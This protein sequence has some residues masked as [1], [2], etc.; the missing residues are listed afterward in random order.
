MKKTFV[1]MGLSFPAFRLFVQ[2][3]V[4]R[5]GGATG[6]GCGTWIFSCC[7]TVLGYL[8]VTLHGA[9]NQMMSL[10]GHSNS[11]AA[12]ESM[13]DDFGKYGRRLCC[14]VQIIRI[15]C[16]CCFCTRLVIRR[17]SQLDVFFTI[18]ERHIFLEVYE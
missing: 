13:E 16:G 12:A 1:F 6:S 9:F 17:K 8:S 7:S 14:L 5:D 15:M 10:A 11:Y 4:I 3:S 2:G 18:K